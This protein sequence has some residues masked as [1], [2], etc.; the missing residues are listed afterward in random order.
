MCEFSADGGSYGTNCRHIPGPYCIHLPA[1][2]FPLLESVLFKFCTGNSKVMFGMELWEMK[3]DRHISPVG[4]FIR[5]VRLL[6][7]VFIIAVPLQEML[8]HL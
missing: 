8:L 5:C 7:G 4:V 1:C 2:H 3:I 6:V